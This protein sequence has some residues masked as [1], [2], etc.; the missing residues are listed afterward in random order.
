[1]AQ[2]KQ[3]N[4]K[5]VRG[6]MRQKQNVKAWDGRFSFIVFNQMV[7]VIMLHTA[8]FTPKQGK[9]LSSFL[10]RVFPSL[11]IVFLRI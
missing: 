7:F 2:Y 5:C 3:P 9:V 10:R 11:D 6:K 4:I 8:F 1:M